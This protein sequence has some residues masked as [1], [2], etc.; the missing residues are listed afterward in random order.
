[1]K[2]IFTLACMAA[3]AMSVNAQEIFDIQSILTTNSDGKY[4]KIADGQSVTVA[5]TSENNKGAGSEDAPLPKGTT[6]AEAF[7]QATTAALNDYTIVASTPSCTMTFVSTPNEND[8]TPE[9]AWGVSDQTGANGSLATDACDPKFN[10]YVSGKGNPTS[11]YFGYWVL[12][13]NG[14]PSFKC[15]NDYQAFWEPTAGAAP[16]KGA[17][18]SFKLSSEGTLKIGVRI[19]KA[20]QNRKI[21][22]VKKSDGTVLEQDK[23]SAEGYNNN[24]T[25]EY[26]TY[27]TADYSVCPGASA[28]FIG[29]INVTLPANEEYVMFSPDTQIGIFGFQFTETTGINTVKNAAETA[30]APKYNIAGQQVEQGYKGMVIQNGKK[31]IVK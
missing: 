8:N 14:D 15:P 20:A 16:S 31:F 27:T 30:N 29:Y 4:T 9:N 22:F 18:T 2:K 1:M 23:Y 10:V 7:A 28:Q 5:N 21:Y 17:Y 26:S 24:N 11:T 12:N 19:P 3:M 25:T 6:D 13:D